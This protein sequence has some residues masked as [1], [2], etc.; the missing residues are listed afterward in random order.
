MI[1]VGVIGLGFGAA[2]H[3]PAF[4]ALP[5]VQVVALGGQRPGK[6]RELASRLGIALGGTIEEV[7]GA[8]LD[9]VTIALPPEAGAQVA[10]A[11]LERGLA[12]MAEKPLA[13]TVERAEALAQLAVGHTT[14]VGFEL[15]ELECFQAL[16][17]A[18]EAQARP[19]SVRLSW[20]TRSYAHSN[21]IWNW[22]TD[23][24][25]HGGVMNLLGSHILYLAEWLFGP[26]AEIRATYSDERTA[27]FAPTGEQPAED[28]ASIQAVTAGGV[29]IGIELDNAAG[30][31]GMRWEL[32]LPQGRLLLEERAGG[33]LA[34]GRTGGA[35]P[36]LLATD[37]PP[38]GVDWRIAPF[39]RLAGRFAG[40]VPQRAACTPDFRAGARVQ[41]LLEFA[42][43]SARRNG[44]P[45]VI[46]P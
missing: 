46:A 42:A 24:R 43:E 39:R 40:C 44:A 45:L 27:A 33:G 19:G 8:G 35:S 2:V 20:R 6:A 22:K 32:D 11:A 3:V 25:R 29:R 36:E 12:V 16:K 31:S 37:I 1:R 10:Q 9:A 13:H 17:R 30:E 7:L 5:G 26:L 38:A 28:R 14:A 4:A 15:A 21:R 23:R 34:L 18:L 41:R